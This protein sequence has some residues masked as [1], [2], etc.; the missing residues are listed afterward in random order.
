MPTL[1]QL[2][3]IRQLAK[4]QFEQDFKDSDHTL[5]DVEYEAHALAALEA[6]DAWVEDFWGI[7]LENPLRPHMTPSPRTRPPTRTPPN[8]RTP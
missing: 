7:E 4:R 3:Q 2:T 6:F 1:D 8:H 5:D